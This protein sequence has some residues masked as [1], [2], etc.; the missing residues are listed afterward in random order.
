MSNATSSIAGAPIETVYK[1]GLKTVLIIDD[2]AVGRKSAA[3]VLK[4]AGFATLAAE[5]G[6]AAFEILDAQV[7]DLIV[8]DYQMPEMNGLEFLRRLR[9]DSRYREV[10]V[11]MLTSACDKLVVAEAM[12]LGIVGYL[13]KSKHVLKELPARVC[14]VFTIPTP[15]GVGGSQRGKES[16][17]PAIVAPIEE[18][19][20]SNNAASAEQLEIINLVQREKTIET[21]LNLTRARTLPGI[22]R[23]VKDLCSA[24]TTNL[25]ELAA[26]IGQDPI[27]SV[28]VLLLARSTSKGRAK[29]CTLHDAI[30]T[31]GPDPIAKLASS[32]E[33]L[34]SL[35][36]GKENWLGLLSCWEHAIATAT[37]MSKL[38][39]A[40]D[41]VRA[42]VP[43]LIGL[44]HNLVELL[45]RQYFPDEYSAAER[46]SMKAGRP[47]REL[48]L[49]VFG[50]SYEELTQCL[51]DS[52]ML[53][54]DL[55]DPILEFARKANA[56]PEA[57]TSMLSRSLS[58]SV[59]YVNGL[60]QSV[61]RN[62]RISPV[63]L[64]DCQKLL[65]QTVALNAAEIRSEA[66]SQ[67]CMLAELTAE[68]EECI[69]KP[70]GKSEVQ[71]WY[72]RH[73][74][75]SA[76]DPLGAALAQLCDLRVN[77]RVPSSRELSGLKGMV[78]VESRQD[79]SLMAEYRRLG[80]ASGTIPL[81]YLSSADGSA[82]KPNRPGFKRIMYPVSLRQLDGFI[83]TLIPD[84]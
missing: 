13:L 64:A 1:T 29:S 15:A 26:I 25:A 19:A 81:L 43:R 38:V 17:F 22:V 5:T 53:P 47:T 11:I 14:R 56:P 40:S 72:A 73:P 10:K 3:M 55:A 45:L 75:F 4:D 58:I 71:V 62:E 39:H 2:A 33:I 76:M 78:I 54:S 48:T 24:G 61:S 9:A 52:L 83:S 41:Q 80:T 16:Q 57:C 46:H 44:C 31:V 7:V 79:D 28:R 27:L 63:A 69:L 59:S 20:D 37:I 77:S 68:H 8:L 42:G 49:S 6:A 65:I 23:T 32:A 67:V 66:V 21:V 50:I 70:R 51:L 82:G 35:E 36:P 18:S 84:S 74:S 30:R 34:T 60:I 12:Q